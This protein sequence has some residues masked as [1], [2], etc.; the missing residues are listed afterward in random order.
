[1][2]RYWI[3]LSPRDSVKMSIGS[4][5]WQLLG[6]ARADREVHKLIYDDVICAFNTYY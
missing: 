1:M 5:L 4:R 3:L 6:V 2:V